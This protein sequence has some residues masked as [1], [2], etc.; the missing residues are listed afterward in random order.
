M[1]IVVVCLFYFFQLDVI[2]ERHY[3]NI[4]VYTL[5]NNIRKNVYII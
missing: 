5:Q 3:T 4:G 1:G 2:T